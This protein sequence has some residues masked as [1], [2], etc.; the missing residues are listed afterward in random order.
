M[1][2]EF[3]KYFL[4]HH[5]FFLIISFSHK[6]YST[7]SKY[8]FRNIVISF[9][10]WRA[11]KIP[12]SKCKRNPRGKSGTSWLDNNRTNGILYFGNGS[13][14]MKEVVPGD[15]PFASKRNRPAFNPFAF[16]RTRDG[17]TMK[18][19]FARSRIFD[20]TSV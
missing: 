3:L 17:C 11:M 2:L 7:F 5:F 14:M 10:R 12:V 18:C 13:S 16:S 19:N 20:E 4:Y 6:F 9:P 8:I 15:V 1:K